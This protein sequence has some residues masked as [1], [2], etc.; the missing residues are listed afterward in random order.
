MSSGWSRSKVENMALTDR[1]KRITDIHSNQQVL[2]AI[3]HLRTA[4]LNRANVKMNVLKILTL[5]YH[6]ND[7]KVNT[8]LYEV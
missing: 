1:T 7:N 8:V 6:I 3:F 2:I 4:A 5:R